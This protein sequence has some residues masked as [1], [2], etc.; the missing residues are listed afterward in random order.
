MLEFHLENYQLERL[1][2]IN[3]ICCGVLETQ[4]EDKPKKNPNKSMN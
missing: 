3:N 1:K 2:I 4:G